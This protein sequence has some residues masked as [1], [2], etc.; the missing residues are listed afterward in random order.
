MWVLRIDP[1]SSARAVNALSAEPSLTKGV[2]KE[3]GDC[4]QEQ[5]PSAVSFKLRTEWLGVGEG[6]KKD[7][8]VD[9]SDPG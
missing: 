2:F 7:R 8:H 6:S 3:W 5:H 1:R 4:L 9:A